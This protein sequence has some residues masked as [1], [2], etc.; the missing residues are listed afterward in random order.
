MRPD[1]QTSL[2]R[3]PLSALLAAVLGLA[4]LVGNGQAYSEVTAPVQ[5]RTAAG[6]VAVV[7]PDIGEPYHSV[8]EQIISGV[9]D[10]TGGRV[11][12]Y[13][14]GTESDYA[15]LKDSLRRQGVRVVIALGLQGVKFAATLDRDTG[16]VAGGIVSPVE[17][18]LRGAPVNSLSPDPS[19][20]FARLKTL[21]PGARR[22]HAVYEPRQSG[23]LIR[24][25]REAARAQGLE[26]VAHEVQDLRGAANAYQDIFATSDARRDAIWLLQ[27]TVGAEGGVVLPLVLQEAWNRNLTV[28]SS[29]FGHVRRGALFS[30]YPDNVGLGRHLAGSAE[31]FLTSGGYDESGLILL[32]DVQMAINLRT[33]SHLGMRPGRKQDFGMVFP[34]Q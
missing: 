6:Q 28:F 4:L 14:V 17:S 26:L 22:V 24:L 1:K 16:V 15:Q 11:A 8:F 18:E 9:E 29:N 12:S 7:Y 31:S 19:L 5:G 34:E 13:P 27:D 21:M 32:R 20:L 25:A 33:A 30:L 23:W 10:R 2:S 3:H